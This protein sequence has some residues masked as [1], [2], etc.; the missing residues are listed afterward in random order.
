LQGNARETRKGFRQRGRSVPA[1][2]G[3]HRVK[4]IMKFVTEDESIHSKYG[5]AKETDSERARRKNIEFKEIQ[6]R[7]Y[8][9]TVG[10]N[11]SCSS[12]PPMS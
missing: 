7:E 1:N 2:L 5:E 4:G 12:G 11:P 9:R 10:D 3:S 6:I 8:A